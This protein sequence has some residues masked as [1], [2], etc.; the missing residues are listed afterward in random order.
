MIRLLPTNASTTMALPT[1]RHSNSTHHPP[2]NA[3]H[4]FTRTPTSTHLPF[5]YQTIQPAPLKPPPK[6]PGSGNATSASGNHTNIAQRFF[7]VLGG[8][9]GAVILLSVLRCIYVYRKTPPTNRSNPEVTERDRLMALLRTVPWRSPPAP[10]PPPPY[11]HA[12]EYST[13]VD[14]RNEQWEPQPPDRT[15]DPASAEHHVVVSPV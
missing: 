11:Q 4:N 8:I 13:V 12:P 14:N 15:H 2:S 6:P 1:N 9:V 10:P 7:E 5:P 3:T